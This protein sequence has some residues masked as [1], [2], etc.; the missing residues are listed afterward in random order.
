M[1]DDLKLMPKLD[2][3]ASLG[4]SSKEFRQDVSGDPKWTERST[5]QLVESI[6]KAMEA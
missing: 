2:T 6:E 3:A 5:L 1:L 4:S